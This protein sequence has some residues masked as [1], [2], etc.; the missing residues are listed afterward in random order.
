MQLK[1]L[2][3]FL[4]NQPGHLNHIC[5]VL[6]KANVNITTLT[7]ADTYEYG[8]LRL[9]IREWESAKKILEKAGYVVNVTDVMAIEVADKPGGL[10]NVLNFTGQA[11]L[12]VEYMY[13]LTIK[14]NRNALLVIRFNDMNTAAE[15]FKNKDIG[16]VSANEFYEKS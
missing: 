9:M 13:A 5:R 6:S 12:S 11:G 1:Q 4:E 15:L 8:I 7:L 14:R 2:S 10:E 16:F 3:V